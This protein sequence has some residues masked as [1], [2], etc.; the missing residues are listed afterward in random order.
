[1]KLLPRRCWLLSAFWLGM[2]P[3]LTAQVPPTGPTIEKIEIQHV[4]PPAVS[5]DLIR[6]NI[7]VKAGDSYSVSATDDDVHTLMGT[8]YFAEVRVRAERTD[9]GVKLTYVVQGKF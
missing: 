8:G 5:D 9:G 4:G 6:A 2:L 7:H 3:L 1:M